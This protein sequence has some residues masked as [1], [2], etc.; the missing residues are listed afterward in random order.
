MNFKGFLNDYSI[1]LK[2]IP[3]PKLK[4]LRNCLQE[5]PGLL[6]KYK[7]NYPSLKQKLKQKGLPLIL[8]TK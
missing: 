5:M 2:P 3:W 6:Q 7:P 4:G 8:T 1:F